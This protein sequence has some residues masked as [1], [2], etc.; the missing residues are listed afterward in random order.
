MQ[1]I[2]NTYIITEYV[3]CSN[4]GLIRKKTGV[5]SAKVDEDEHSRRGKYKREPVAENKTDALTVSIVTGIITPPNNWWEMVSSLKGYL[6]ESSLQKKPRR[7]G[8]CRTLS[9]TNGSPTSR[10]AMREETKKQNS[11]YKITSVGLG[12]PTHDATLRAC[13]KQETKHRILW[14]RRRRPRQLSGALKCKY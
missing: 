11:G 12:L 5:K 9:I 1:A 10:E 13:A 14:R 8:L 7:K 2:K 6:I 4:Y 3:F